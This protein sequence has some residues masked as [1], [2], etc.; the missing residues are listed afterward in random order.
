MKNLSA[1][2]ARVGRGA[3]SA[4]DYRS[5]NSRRGVILVTVEHASNL[6]PE[7]YSFQNQLYSGSE[8]EL[9]RGALLGN[10][11]WAWDPGSSLA[12]HDIG[13]VLFIIRRIAQAIRYIYIFL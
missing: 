11:H 10:S 6:L 2:V 13:K 5:G 7:G 8:E 1:V 9:S 4:C 12:A 3:A